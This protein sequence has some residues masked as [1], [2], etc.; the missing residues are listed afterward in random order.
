LRALREALRLDLPIEARQEVL[1]MACLQPGPEVIKG[2]ILEGPG[3][4]YPKP[5]VQALL[6]IES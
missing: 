6:V 4:D 2:H 1:A 3:M 5:G